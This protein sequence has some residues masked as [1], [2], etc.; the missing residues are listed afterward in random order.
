LNP[1]IPDAMA[2]SPANSPIAIRLTISFVALLALLIGLSAMTLFRM[3]QVS[4]ALDRLDSD[5]LE[6]LT[7][8][9]DIDENAED[10]ARKL[11]VLIS[12]ERDERVLAYAEI[13]AANRRLDSSMRLLDA[14]LPGGDRRALFLSVQ[15]KLRA[16]RIRY[17]LNVELIEAEDWKAARRMLVEKTEG[18]LS[19]LAS[20]NDALARSE[21]DSTTKETERLK[22]RLSTDRSIV[23]VLCVFGVGL[24]GSLALLVTRGIV[25]PLRRAE[26]AALRLTAGDYSSRVDVISEDEVGRVSQAL[27]S[28]ALAVGDREAAL[29][30]LASTDTLTGLAQRARFVADGN[31]LMH[32]LRLAGGTA[33]LLCMDIDRLKLINSILGFDAGDAAIVDGARRIEAIVSPHGA[34]G[35]LAGGTFAALVRS[36]ALNDA[37]TWAARV[38]NEVDR[39]VN[40]G[41]QSLDLSLTIG[42]A[43]WP[44]QAAD[45]ET[46][47][48]CAEHAMYEAKRQR[49]PTA[50]YVSSAEATRASHLTLLS[51]LTEAIAS[52]QLRMFVQP[53]ISA[54]DLQ[55]RGVEAL[56][57]WQHPVRGWI[58]PAEFIPFAESTGRIRQ[59]TQW[60]LEQ[61]IAT[62]AEWQTSGIELSIAVNVSTVDLQDKTLPARVLEMLR[63][64]GVAPHRLQLELTET[65]LMSSGPDPIAVLHSLR[66]I[67]VRLAIDDFGTG[68]SSLGYLQRL[69]VHE[70]KIDRSFV[71][72]FNA[73]AKR[74]QLLSSIVALGHSLGLV[75]TAEG[76]ETPDELSALAAL[77]C[78]LI[79]G[80]LIAKPMAVSHFTA[81][82]T[83]W[84]AQAAAKSSAVEKVAP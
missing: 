78:D 59:V 76:V 79:Q 14:R 55:P 29:T 69:P 39:Q 80:F 42:V 82:R 25:I 28:L 52:R 10:A 64:A 65:G 8:V 15:E 81:W 5:Q 33:T 1:T 12:A 3:E 67:G 31:A 6:N 83:A 38:Q 11:L 54:V 36:D 26:A 43:D 63:T 75:V 73:D 23:V 84:A 68:Q 61:A 66:N 7:L 2:R 48:R 71:D 24:G 50:A 74:Q 57:R 16:Y 77:G 17:N 56:V 40:W 32:S 18:A 62:L 51:E 37:M 70:L 53:K 9:A 44:A 34:L 41:G 45:C 30:R 22:A 4:R 49:L 72:G 46:L 20:A 27:N 58:S 47:L 60:M 21:H 35:R 13:D 19:E